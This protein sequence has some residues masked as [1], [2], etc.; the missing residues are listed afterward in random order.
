M[1]GAEP[2]D[3]PIPTI[4]PAM[5]PAISVLRAHLLGDQI[6]LA[7]V[8]SGQTSNALLAGMTTLAQLLGE[9]LYGQ[10]LPDVLRRMCEQHVPTD[11]ADPDVVEADQLAALDMLVCTIT[12]DMAGWQAALSRGGDPRA[13]IN[14]LLSLGYALL[15]TAPCRDDD[16]AVGKLREISQMVATRKALGD[17]DAALSG[18]HWGEA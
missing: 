12:G 14:G 13:V 4:G 8:A 6:R 11:K 16:E 7:A 3:P 2:K 5:V 1:T 15:F 10:E 17:T 9:Q 18:L